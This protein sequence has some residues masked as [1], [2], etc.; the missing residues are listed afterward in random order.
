MTDVPPP[1]AG[2]KFRTLTNMRNP[3]ESSWW[4]CLPMIHGQKTPLRSIVD[5]VDMFILIYNNNK[6]TVA[7]IMSHNHPGRSQKQVPN[8]RPKEYI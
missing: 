3:A 4:I 8:A 5:A 6:G 1:T 7:V 2:V